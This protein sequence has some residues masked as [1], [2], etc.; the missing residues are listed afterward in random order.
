MVALGNQML[1]CGLLDPL[2]L[3]ELENIA[4]T[5]ASDVVSMIFVLEH[6]ANPV[7]LMKALSS[8]RNIRY[9]FL[10]VPTVSPAM[11]VELAFPGIFERHLSAHTHL[12]SDG[13]LDYLTEQT[14]FERIAEW[15]FG[16][17]VMDLFR[18]VIV[19]MRQDGHGE[20]TVK[21]WMTMM[22]PVID[23]WQVALDQRRLASEVHVVLRRT[24]R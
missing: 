4:A 17:D 15:W 10:A 3:D 20:A 14:G 2:A 7:R 19:R 23:D 24:S 11:F 16:A 9:L 1:G 13:S 22:R 18:S 12:F 8:N 5:L 6:V 21:A